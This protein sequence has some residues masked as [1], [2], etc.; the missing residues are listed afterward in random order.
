MKP[1]LLQ[2]KERGYFT[3][4]LKSRALALESIYAVRFYEIIKR[5]EYEGSFTLS[6]SELRVIFN[7]E[8][9]YKRFRDL[10]KRVIDQAK[11]ELDRRCD[12]TFEYEIIRK[13]RSPHKVRFRVRPNL[14]SDALEPPDSTSTPK[15]SSPPPPPP[16][17]GKSRA[18]KRFD[19][20]DDAEKERVLQQ[21]QQLAEK[22]NPGVSGRVLEAQVWR[23]VWRIMEQE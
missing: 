8:D 4:Y 22:Q 21:A 2:L 18:E 16:E 14:D 1:L 11:K 3:M 13:G 9:K 15:V 10:R 7:L 23:Y 20:L 5:Y 17:S 12:V 19:A 6:I